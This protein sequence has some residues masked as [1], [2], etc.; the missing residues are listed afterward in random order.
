MTKEISAPARVKGPITDP[1]GKQRVGLKAT[2]TIIRKNYGLTWNKAMETG[3]LMVG[4]E[5]Q[6]E[7]N[8]EAVQQ[9]AAVK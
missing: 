3:G 2:L 9:D 8:A 4:E 7:I 5:V 1:W 6:I